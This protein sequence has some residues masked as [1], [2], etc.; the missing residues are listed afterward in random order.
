MGESTEAA[1][2]EWALS[3]KEFLAM[4]GMLGFVA[5]TG[6]GLSGCSEETEEETLLEG[7]E[8]MDTLEMLKNKME[9][10]ELKSD[11]WWYL[12]SKQ[13]DKLLSDVFTED[14]KLYVGMPGMGDEAIQTASSAKEWAENTSGQLTG[15]TTAHQ[16]HQAKIKI[17]SDTTAIGR[18]VLND[19]LL[20]PDGQSMMYGYAYYIDDFIKIDGKWKID[21]IRLGY[22]MVENGTATATPGGFYYPEG[23]F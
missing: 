7:I 5:A 2:A 22:I 21:A 8:K 16:G 10:E 18:F 13:F 3:R 17:T 6:I 15:V 9:I 1:E 14:L 23:D 20:F 11:Y 19:H 4:A 12:D